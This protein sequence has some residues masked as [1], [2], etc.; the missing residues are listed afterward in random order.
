[1]GHEDEQWFKDMQFVD[2]L[3]QDWSKR[4]QSVSSPLSPVE[5]V[6][7]LAIDHLI[8]ME[9][10]Y[11]G[12]L[13]HDDGPEPGRETMEALR[14]LG[15]DRYANDLQRV[16][17]MHTVQMLGRLRCLSCRVTLTVAWSL[18]QLSPGMCANARAETP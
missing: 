10:G 16:Y 4:E 9:A 2:E 3:Y 13:S 17:A 8:N 7:Y 15:L 18:K 12:S 1:M 14:V 11:Y 6:G 5:W